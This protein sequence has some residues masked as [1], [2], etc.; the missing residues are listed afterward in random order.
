MTAAMMPELSPDPAA[1]QREF[2]YQV[3]SLQ[4]VSK[5]QSRYIHS[6]LAFIALVWTV[7]FLR[8][9]PN[10]AVPVYGV[11]LNLTGIWAVAPA[12]ITVLTLGLIG[13]INAMGPVWWRISVSAEKLGQKFWFPDLDIHR[14][15]VDYVSAL[16]I[17]PEAQVEPRTSPTTLSQKG[18]RS[19]FLYPLVI[20]GAVTTTVFADYPHALM[21]FRI[22]V[23]GCAAI[24]LLF[25]FRIFY[26]QTCRYFGRRTEQTT[27]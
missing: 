10:T 2:E 7:D 16:R 8:P 4:A 17:H 5:A 23:Y 20:A 9:N 22:Y 25:G 26:R 15:I 6:L 12:V 21:T 14:N 3:A 13:T 1:I 19:L 24:Q 18:N 27:F 11:P